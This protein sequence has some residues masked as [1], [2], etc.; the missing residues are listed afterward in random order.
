M[1]DDYDEFTQ[2]MTSFDLVLGDEDPIEETTDTSES[3]KPIR[4]QSNER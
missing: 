4:R 2:R 3:K 1:T